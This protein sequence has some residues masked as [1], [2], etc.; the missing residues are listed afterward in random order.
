M[1]VGWT[2]VHELVMPFNHLILCRP[3]VLLPSFLLNI[4][5]FSSSHVW[6]WKWDHKESW[7]LKNWCFWTV[8]LKKSLESPLDCKEIKP[9]NP[10]GNQSWIFFGRSDAEAP[11]LWLPDAKNLLTGKYPDVEKEWRQEDKGTT[12]DEMVEWHH[13]LM[14]MSSTNLHELVMDRKAWSAAVHGVIKSQTLSN[15]TE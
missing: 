3:L 2:H 6:M 11:I 13:Q 14:N 7:V 1:E 12:E 9:V 15:W 10:K 4:R 8:V 5:V